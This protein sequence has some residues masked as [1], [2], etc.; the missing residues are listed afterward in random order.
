M[1]EAMSTHEAFSVLDGLVWRVIIW[2]LFR[3]L[4]PTLGIVRTLELN[5]SKIKN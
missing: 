1:G 2:Y 5:V 4:I 3:Q